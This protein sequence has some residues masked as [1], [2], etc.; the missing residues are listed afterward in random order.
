MWDVRCK[1]KGG[2]EVRKGQEVVGEGRVVKRE[3]EG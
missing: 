2:E 3:R 1:A